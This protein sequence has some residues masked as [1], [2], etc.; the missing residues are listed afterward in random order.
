MAKNHQE[1]Q[2]RE[3]YASP[4]RKSKPAR[5]QQARE[6]QL[7]ALAMDVAEKQMRSGKVSSQVLTHF[8]KLGTVQ[9]EL[10]LEKTKHENELLRAKTENIKAQENS[11][12][13]YAEVIAAMRKYSGSLGNE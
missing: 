1:D 10:E 4:K 8:L 9:A 13:K 3:P 5:T 11:E 2:E 7:T 12:K 6:K